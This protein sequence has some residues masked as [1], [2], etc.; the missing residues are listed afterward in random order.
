MTCAFSYIIYVL[1]HIQS[2]QK[3]VMYI[4]QKQKFDGS[5]SRSSKKFNQ[6]KGNFRV[7]FSLKT[8]KKIKLTKFTHYFPLNHQ[9]IILALKKKHKHISKHKILGGVIFATR[10]HKS[11][12]NWCNQD[13]EL[14]LIV[15]IIMVKGIILV[16]L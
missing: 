8:W 3:G 12:T 13:F 6:K 10:W 4:K 1:L 15:N 16:D 5:K 11:V 7:F 14:C 2:N 9:T